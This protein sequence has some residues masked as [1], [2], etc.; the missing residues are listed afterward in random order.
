MISLSLPL[1]VALVSLSPA[2]G[3]AVQRPSVA[4]AQP[5]GEPAIAPAVIEGEAA[6][7]PEVAPAEP[8]PAE[9]APAEPAPDSG[10]PS[11]DSTPAEPAPDTVTVEPQPDPGLPSWDTSPTV[12]TGGE[13]DMPQVDEWGVPVEPVDNSPRKGGGFYVGAS[14]MFGAMITKQM[15]MGIFCSDA[16]C[17]YRG[18]F[19]RV[20]AFGTMGFVA[21]AGWYDGRRK[22]YFELKDG[23]EQ[24][25]LKKKR[26]VG[27]SLFA[28]GM[29]GLLTDMVLY[30]VCYDGAA[31]PYRQLEG[32][33]Y[34]CTPVASVLTLDFSTILASV[35]LGFGMSAQSQKRHRERNNFDLGLAPFGGRGQAG[36][37]LSG[38]F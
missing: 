2:D 23:V 4:P 14:V 15:F 13:G 38:R 11:Y 5:E 9:P 32:F 36:L 8:A 26:T 17:G 28:V 21:G 31:G 33:S 24:R 25:S 27:W 10:L 29:A 7:T 34:D 19:D 12:P 20:M 3:P 1:C 37:S 35:G 6:A 22:A 30:H 18:N 16:Y